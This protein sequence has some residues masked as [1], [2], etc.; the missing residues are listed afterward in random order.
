MFAKSIEYEH[1]MGRWSRQLSPLHIAFAEVKDGDKV[2]DVGAGTGGLALPLAAR[3][4]S[5]EIVG[6][7]P[8]ADSIAYARAHATPHMH[9]DVGDA[10]ALP[11]ESGRFDRAMA[12]LV[13][14]FIPDHEKALREMMRVTRPGGTISA[15]V[16]DYDAGMQMLRLFFDEAVALDPAA[17]SKDERHMKLSHPGELAALWQKAGLVSVD[18]QP[19]D[20]DM[21]FTSFDD[22]WDPF[23]HGAGPAGAYLATRDAPA[24]AALEARLRKRV[25]GDRPDGPFTLKARAWCVRGVVPAATR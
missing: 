17:E 6:I 24:R 18:E 8:S 15:C 10:Q 3:T 11:Y 25:L 22:Y 5:C 1:F 14:N 12:Q 20:M 7:D 9:F 23:L 21:R 16:W 2:L 19:L 13:M 4:P